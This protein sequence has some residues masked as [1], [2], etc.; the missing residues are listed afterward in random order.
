[1]LHTLQVSLLSPAD[2]LSP[3]GGTQQSHESDAATK[4]PGRQGLELRLRLQASRT[5]GMRRGGSALRR[6]N[7]LASGVNW[8][9]VMVTCVSVSGHI[10][11][12]SSTC[13]NSII[14]MVVFKTS[15]SVDEN[16]GKRG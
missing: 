13:F 14:P 5:Q 1:M 9:W 15:H 10:V 11:L 2:T 3:W 7:V 4:T 6:I 8:R 12:D 16:W